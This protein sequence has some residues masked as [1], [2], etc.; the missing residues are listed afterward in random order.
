ELCTEE[1]WLLPNVTPR[2]IDP[3]ELRSPKNFCLS[4]LTRTA[5]STMMRFWV[6]IKSSVSRANTSCSSFAARMESFLMLSFGRLGF[7]QLKICALCRIKQDRN[8]MKNRN[9]FAKTITQKRC[10]SNEKYAAELQWI[11]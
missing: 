2:I 1:P 5:S 10:K 6:R 11:T 9:F 3:L 4:F 8:R 7:F